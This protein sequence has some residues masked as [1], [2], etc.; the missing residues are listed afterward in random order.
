MK[1]T[2]N[3]LTCM[4]FGHTF[5]KQPLLDDKTCARCGYFQRLRLFSRRYSR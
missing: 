3:K 5:G 1:K 4:V 2:I